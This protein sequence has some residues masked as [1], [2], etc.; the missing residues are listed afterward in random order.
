MIRPLPHDPVIRQLVQQA[1]AA[2]L[3]RRTLLKGAGV[4]ATTFALAACS[5]SAKQLTPAK[6]Q[7]ATDKSLVWANWPS[8]LDQ[9]KNAK[10]YPTLTAFTK[11]TGIKVDY[12][13]D[14][15][16]NNSYFA[17]VRD[18]LQKGRPIG[19]DTVVLT[20]WMV[21]RLIRLGYVQEFDRAAMPNTKNLIPNLK[22]PDY[23]RGRR[24][25]MPW[26]GGYTGIV[27]NTEKYSGELRRVQDL[28][29]PEFK[30]KV[31]VLSEMRDTIGLIM[32]DQGVDI[33]SGWGKTQFDRG[34]AVFQKQIKDGQIRNVK[35]NS[36]L[37]DL[38]NGDTVAAIAWSGDITTLNAE[39]GSEKFK[40]VIP[41]PGGMLW[42]DIFVVPM[43]SNQL[44][45]VEKLINYYYEPEV[46]AQVAA[47][48]NY[49]TPVA[50]AAAAA[51]KIDPALAKNQLIFPNAD[52][53]KT[54][55]TFRT[56]TPQ[57]DQDFG[58]R[59]QSVLL[60]A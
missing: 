12:R 18:Q 1:R 33:T 51:E 39:I 54:V 11:R 29:A 10:D 26:Q 16:D 14:V 8:Y 58:T 59:F 19:A 49:V 4:G 2:Q 56:L 40:F 22:N 47:Y 13:V 34:L 27:W 60:G 7:S 25:S 43:G 5:A 37:Q 3:S 52:T 32:L 44:G 24:R 23:D 21:S 36:Y 9:G 48:V 6:D 38:Q 35:G 53:L 15:D 17:K 42:N 46:A 31:G 28:W 30:G 41:E 57:E 55:R 50:G 20:D 45:N